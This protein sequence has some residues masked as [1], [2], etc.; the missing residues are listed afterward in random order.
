MECVTEFVIPL[1]I[2]SHLAIDAAHL[3]D[4]YLIII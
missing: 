4:S 3:G 2:K 1:A